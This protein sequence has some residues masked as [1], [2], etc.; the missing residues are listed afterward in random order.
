MMTRAASL[1]IATAAAAPLLIGV[2]ALW[3]SIKGF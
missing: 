2:A 1:V 3:F